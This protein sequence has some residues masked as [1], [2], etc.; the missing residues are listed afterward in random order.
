MSVRNFTGVPAAAMEFSV[1]E[2]FGCSLG[3]HS[4]PTEQC[5]QNGATGISG[6]QFSEAAGH[7]IS[8]CT[9]AGRHGELGDLY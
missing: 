5:G 7:G 9:I 3:Y 1:A 6:D 8:H 2:S 4:W